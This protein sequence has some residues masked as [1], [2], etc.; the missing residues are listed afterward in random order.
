MTIN[1]LYISQLLS[2]T[3]LTILILEYHD[4]LPFCYTNEVNNFHHLIWNV[5]DTY[6]YKLY[7]ML[8]ILYQNHNQ[9]HGHTK[10]ILNEATY[11]STRATRQMHEV[12][13]NKF[14]FLTFLIISL[15]YTPIALVFKKIT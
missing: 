2:I 10:S 7:N 12:I 1:S 5:I 6:T 3:Q 15:V 9:I 11:V 13:T 4:I 8:Y 14:I